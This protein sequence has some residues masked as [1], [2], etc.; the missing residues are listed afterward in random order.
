MLSHCK[1]FVGHVERRR[2]CHC[3]PEVLQMMLASLDTTGF[4]LTTAQKNI[5][6]FQHNGQ[7][8]FDSTPIECA[9]VT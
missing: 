2:Q 6:I 4:V 3:V 7:M 9:L 8:C 5:F 1:P